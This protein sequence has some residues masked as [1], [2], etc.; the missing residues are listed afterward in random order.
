MLRGPWGVAAPARHPHSVRC[1]LF[2][3]VCF[4]ESSAAWPLARGTPVRLLPPLRRFF[5]AI[6]NVVVCVWPWAARP[7]ECRGCPGVGL[8]VQCTL[9]CMPPREPPCAV[10]CYPLRCRCCARAGAAA[11][12]RGYRNSNIYLA[13]RTWGH[14]SSSTRRPRV[15]ALPPGKW[16]V[17]VATTP[18][19]IRGLWCLPCACVSGCGQPPP[20]SGSQESTGPHLFA[21]SV[22]AVAAVGGTPQAR[23]GG[24]ARVHQASASGGPL[25]PLWTRQHQCVAPAPTRSPRA[26]RCEREP[27]RGINVDG[28]TRN[29]L[30]G[31]RGTFQAP[32]TR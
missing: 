8:A 14:R 11:T 19:T 4:A 27:L 9:C 25:L 29:L 7:G 6:G 21:E 2:C 13:T 16:Q 28:C 12:D 32:S 17:C 18:E 1:P 26:C 15:T 23:G 5:N 10:V 30:M 24:R 20:L 31:I 22:A 3:V